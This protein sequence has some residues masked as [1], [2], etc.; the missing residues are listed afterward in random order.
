METTMTTRLEQYDTA[1]DLVVKLS[2]CINDTSVAGTDPPHVER[3]MADHV[4]KLITGQLK[5]VELLLHDHAAIYGV[6]DKNPS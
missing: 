3:V 4:R 2:R 5:I 1:I 6:F